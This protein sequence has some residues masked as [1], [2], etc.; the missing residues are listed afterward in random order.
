M[1]KR[2]MS[3]VAIGLAASLLAACSGATKP[4]QE[5]SKPTESAAQQESSFDAKAV[6]VALLTD[7]AGTQPFILDMIKG[8]KDGESKYGFQGNVIECKSEADY[9]ANARALIEEG[10]NFI[11]GGG[12]QTSSA[13]TKVATEFPDKADYAIIDTQV[14]VPNI[15]CINFREQEGAYLVGR[16]AG[17]VTK[18]E[19]KLFGAVHVFDGPG[20]WKWRYG[21]QEG[22]KS[23]KPDAEFIFNFV[24]SFSDPA[25]AKEFALQQAERGC[26][27]INSGA[28]GGDSG[29]FE[30]AKE[31]QFFTSGQDIDL[32]TPENP[33]VL[34]CQL[35]NTDETVLYLLGEY[36]KNEHKDWNTENIELGIQE[37]AIGA[38]FITEDSKT[39]RNPIF[40]DEILTKLQA[41]VEEIRSG[42]LDLVKMPDE[43]DYH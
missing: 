37:G 13:L 34:T 9:E 5:E 27:F 36:F 1:K 22:V 31:K 21:F 25:K 14:D 24:G 8:F 38:V 17:L 7:E 33:Y 35:K 28:A 20:S 26:E 29:V 40:S 18:P 30:A 32:T 42:K 6:K 3:I 4:S 39:T 41:S 43:K 15:K 12:W 16:L 10:Y 2:W 23:V 11:I 19:S